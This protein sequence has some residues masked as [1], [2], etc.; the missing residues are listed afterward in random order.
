MSDFA[1]ICPQPSAS[2]SKREKEREKI[3]H[4]KKSSILEGMTHDA[5]HVLHKSM[6]LL[7][8]SAHNFTG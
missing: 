2:S 7:K 1:I 3:L 6:N 8:I 4:G 5:S